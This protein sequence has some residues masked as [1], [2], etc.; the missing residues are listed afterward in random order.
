MRPRVCLVLALAMAGAFLAPA[1]L[2]WAGG[3]EPAETGGASGARDIGLEADR[4]LRAMGAYLHAAEEFTFEADV[5]YDSGAM[6]Q[7]GGVVKVAA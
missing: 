3:S 2:A 1:P 5:T 4:V 7:Y 6:I